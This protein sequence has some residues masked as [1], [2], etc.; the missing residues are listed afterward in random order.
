MSA[1]P[2]RGA[3]PKFGLVSTFTSD[4][5]TKVPEG[6]QVAGSCR[7]AIYGFITSNIRAFDQ[8]LETHQIV[9]KV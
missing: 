8:G 1:G 4:T 5:V 3:T 6:A 2:Q 9:S 7:M